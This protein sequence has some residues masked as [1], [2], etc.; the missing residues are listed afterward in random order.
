M[1]NMSRHLPAGVIL[2]EGWPISVFM[3]R[4][5]ANRYETFTGLILQ[6]EQDSLT[7]NGNPMDGRWVLRGPTG[8]LIDFAP[9]L[10]DIAE[11]N[12]IRFQ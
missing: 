12:N 5:A 6:R 4:T 8:V 7:P 3:V 9:S 10:N 1:N 11:R 2:P